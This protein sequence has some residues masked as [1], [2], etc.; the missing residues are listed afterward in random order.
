[1]AAPQYRPRARLNEA[2]PI[3]WPPEQSP[4][5]KAQGPAPRSSER[6]KQLQR[7][8]RFSILVVVPVLLMLGSIYLH[9]ISAGLGDKVAS[10][11]GRLDLAEAEG[12]KLDVEVARLSAPEKI[13]T[14]AREDL[15]MKDPGAA[16]L[17]V[18]QKDGED[19]N[20]I[21]KEK[22]QSESP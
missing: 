16:D 15:H 10:L 11:Q 13:R 20:Q 19:D 22:A 2:R 12:Q 1:M 9:T 3:G 5:R 8:R 14:R 6:R 17:N 7:R 18:Y 21:G 4:R